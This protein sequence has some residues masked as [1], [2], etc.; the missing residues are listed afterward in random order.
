MVQHTG[1]AARLPR[2]QP[3]DAGVSSSLVSLVVCTAA[4][5]G[6]AAA[7]LGVRAGAGEVHAV[8]TDGA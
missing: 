2:R 1:P 6:G 7:D 3:A 4:L 5:E 8:A